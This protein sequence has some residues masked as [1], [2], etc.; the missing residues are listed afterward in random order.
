MFKRIMSFGAAA[1]AAFTSGCGDGPATVGGTWRSPAAWSSMIYATAKGP[2]LVEVHGDPFGAEPA[3]FRALVASAMTNQII[4]RPTAFT[5][6]PQGAP[7]PHFRVVLAF[8]PPDNADARHL[9]AGQV[10]TAAQAG[11]RITVLG[12][13]CDGAT[14]LASVR[15]W[16]GKAEGPEDKRF[17]QL[18][19][20]VVRDM[21]GNPP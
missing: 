10:A 1:L 16:V 17:R 5:A 2:M 19:G 8:N 9:C 15:G 20:Q 4:G 14:L 18:M 21:F 7:E 12:A 13:F 6:D 3:R 11:D